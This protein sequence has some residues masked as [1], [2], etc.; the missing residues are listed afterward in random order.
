MALNDRTNTLLSIRAFQIVCNA[1]EIEERPGHIPT[2]TM[3]IIYIENW[4][5]L[6]QQDLKLSQ[7][8]EVYLRTRHSVSQAYNRS[9]VRKHQH[10]FPAELFYGG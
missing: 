7:R 1:V 8:N 4:L 10:G 3:Q 2:D 9:D 5:N 6:N